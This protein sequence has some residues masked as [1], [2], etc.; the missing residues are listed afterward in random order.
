MRALLV[1]YFVLGQICTSAVA[2]APTPSVVAEQGSADLIS[3]V[4]AREKS[5]WSAKQRADKATWASLLSDQYSQVNSNGFL[6]DRRE[7]V[8]RFTEQSIEDYSLHDLRGKQIDPDVVVITYWV[9]LKATYLGHVSQGA[10]AVSS[11]W[12]RRNGEWLNAHQQETPRR[13]L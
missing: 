9:E 8:R 6:V 7:A 4:I 3:D 1:G 2:I 5:S 12:F 13:S 10:F 11:V